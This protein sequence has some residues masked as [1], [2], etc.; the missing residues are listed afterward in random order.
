MSS[1][2]REII[3]KSRMNKGEAASSS[4]CD[5]RLPCSLNSP[6]V[7]AFQKQ[8][9]LCATEPHG[10][11]LGLRPDE[12]AALKTL[13][14]QSQTISIPPKKSYNVASAPPEYKDM[15]RE[16]LLVK[17]GLHPGTESVE[18]A[19][20][21]SDTGGDPDLRSCGKPDHLR[22]LSRMDRTR[23][24]SASLSTLIIARSGRSM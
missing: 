13:G 2:K 11:T 8:R 16:W 15:S 10:P 4:D 19:T 1:I 20:H 6:P 24:G 17:N 23:T 18:T 14:K 5:F 3:Y 22:R 7:D 12:S 21:V 9:K